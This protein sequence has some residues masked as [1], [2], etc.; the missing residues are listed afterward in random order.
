L[1]QPIIVLG[2]K[3]DHGGEVIGCA[4]TTD[5]QGRGFARKGDMVSCRRCGGIF[6]IAQGDPSLVVDGAPVAYHGYK[7][8][9]GAMLISSQVLVV[10][11]PSSGAGAVALDGGSSGSIPAGFGSIGER[12]IAGYQDAPLDDQAT[13]FQG[14][15]QVLDR[16][17]SEPVV[18]RDVRVRSTAGQ[19]LTGVTD[20]EGY[21]QWVER[22]TAE[23]LAFDLIDQGK[24][25][26]TA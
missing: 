21:T 6:A 8:T 1:I 24:E 5:A 25:S 7:V 10:G 11:E 19:Y 23:S 15:F 18:G 4:P 9:C 13:R 22:D 12:L 2:D 16:E 26:A 17:T 20:A 3:T 14:R